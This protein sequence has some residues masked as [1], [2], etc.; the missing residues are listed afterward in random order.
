[1]RMFQ[2]LHKYYDDCFS[3]GEFDT[4]K[5]LENGLIDSNYN[6]DNRL[7]M[8]RSV[9]DCVLKSKSIN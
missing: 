9:Y 1:M 6:T 5:V 2:A 7:K 3:N 4:N 8:L